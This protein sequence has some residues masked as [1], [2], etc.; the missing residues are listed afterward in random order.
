MVFS[1]SI[2]AIAL[3]YEHFLWIFARKYLE[4]DFFLIYITPKQDV[5]I[6]KDIK[7]KATFSTDLKT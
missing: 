6:P 5:I 7:N 1:S 3:N 4:D 2:N